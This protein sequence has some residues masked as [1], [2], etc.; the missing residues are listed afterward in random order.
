MALVERRKRVLPILQR[1]VNGEVGVEEMQYVRGPLGIWPYPILNA[2]L[3]F[4]R[5]MR[6]TR[7]PPSAV[8]P[9]GKRRL[10]VY[11]I[12]RDP[13]TGRIMEIAEHEREVYE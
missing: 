10:T 4:I 1:E 12:V 3:H 11:E 9:L 2:L 8:A 13:K 6:E 5:A 7:A